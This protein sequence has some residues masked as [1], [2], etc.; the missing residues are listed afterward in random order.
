MEWV[1]NEGD[2]VMVMIKGYSKNV[3]KCTVGGS[4]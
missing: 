2:K 1:S 3:E 4:V